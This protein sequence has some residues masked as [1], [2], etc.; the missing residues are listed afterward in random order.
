MYRAR[1]YITLKPTVLDAQGAVVEKALHSLG[2]TTVG[3][4][5]IGKYVEARVD[6]GHRDQVENQVREMCDRLLANPVIEDF[7]F[8]LEEA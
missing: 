1:I 6:G 2:Y 4:M 8:E 5:R 7:R 3:D